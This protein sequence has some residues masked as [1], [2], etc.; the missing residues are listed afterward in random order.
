MRVAAATFL[1]MTSSHLQQ[2]IWS[3]ISGGE[4]DVDR[5]TQGP[6]SRSFPT[7]NTSFQSLNG[8]VNRRLSDSSNTFKSSVTMLL[9]SLLITSKPLLLMRMWLGYASIITLWILQLQ[10]LWPLVWEQAAAQLPISRC[11]DG[12]H[13]L[14]DCS[15]IRF[16]GGN[17]SGPLEGGRM[18]DNLEVLVRF[19]VSFW[20]FVYFI[21]TSFIYMHGGLC[22]EFTKLGLIVE[23]FLFWKGIVAV[24]RLHVWLSCNCSFSICTQ[25]KL[26]RLIGETRMP[27]SSL[28]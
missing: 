24:I 19:W 1:W 12:M 4:S 20:C 13:W 17:F 15:R 25:Q 9:V 14:D 22:W 6:D 8:W 21:I 3:M 18:G 2:R 26:A 23:M 10:A 16:V 27:F 11:E 5:E 7:T 28:W